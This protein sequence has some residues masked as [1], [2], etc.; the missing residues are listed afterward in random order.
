M[1]FRSI[2][3][4][5]IYTFILYLFIFYGIIIYVLMVKSQIFLCNN[6]LVVDKSQLPK[7]DLHTHACLIFRHLSHQGL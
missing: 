2:L 6:P 4:S 1:F 5:G 3:F 7:L